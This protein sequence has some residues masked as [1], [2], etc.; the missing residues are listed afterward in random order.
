MEFFRFGHGEKT[1]IILPGLSVRSVMG[2]A[3]TVAS[4]YK[5]LEDTFTIYAFDRHEAL[6]KIIY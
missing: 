5:S 1:L 6:P 4:A 2:A 3:D